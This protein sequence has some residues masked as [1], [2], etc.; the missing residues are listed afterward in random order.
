MAEAAAAPDEAGS[1]GELH[2]G[3]PE[4]DHVGGRLVDTIQDREVV[5][6]VLRGREAEG[7]SDD[8]ALKKILF[9]IKKNS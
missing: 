1:A 4:D 5:G 6:G 9:C 8:E 7:Q 2:V 3:A